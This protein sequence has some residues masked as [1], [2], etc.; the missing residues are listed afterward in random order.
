MKNYI[1]VLKETII[2]KKLEVQTDLKCEGRMQSRSFYRA[3]PKRKKYI[4]KLKNVN[5]FYIAQNIWKSYTKKDQ[6][7]FSH[8]V[9]VLF[10]NTGG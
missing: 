6:M 10:C 3:P 1:R 7:I 4:I 9:T 5:M 8:M 2:N